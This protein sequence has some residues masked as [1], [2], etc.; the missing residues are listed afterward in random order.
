MVHNCY[1]KIV[2]GFLFRPILVEQMQILHHFQM[3]VPQ[4]VKNSSTRNRRLS[5]DDINEENFDDDSVSGDEFHGM[6]EDDDDHSDGDDENIGHDD[7]GSRQHYQ[8]QNVDV[9]H[10][11]KMIPSS[12]AGAMTTGSGS[13][14]SLLT[15]G[16]TVNMNHLD[17][18]GDHAQLHYSMGSKL[19]INMD[20]NA[21]AFC[22][23]MP[24]VM[25]VC[26]DKDLCIGSYLCRCCCC[27]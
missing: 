23:G 1:G 15:E 18:H 11:V 4:N 7:H 22:K 9:D 25:Y 19:N 16:G 2:R 17:P 12:S 5:T 13:M 14:G 20:D 26:S 10:M 8:Q 21:A 3:M 27:S 6:M 24:M